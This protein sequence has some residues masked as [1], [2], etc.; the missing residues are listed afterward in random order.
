MRPRTLT[1][2]MDALRIRGEKLVS[3][4]DAGK[5]TPHTS[6]HPVDHP[7]SEYF[8]DATVFSLIHQRAPKAQQGS[9]A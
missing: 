3:S 9:S 5:Q 4:R 6:E 1:K 8:S 7:V 2:E